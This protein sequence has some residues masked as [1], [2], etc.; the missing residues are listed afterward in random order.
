MCMYF[1]DRLLTQAWEML[2]LFLLRK[3]KYLVTA[4]SSQ[5]LSEEVISRKRA[6][7]FKGLHPFD[8]EDAGW[9]QLNWK[10]AWIFLFR[11]S[12]NKRCLPKTLAVP[13]HYGKCIN[14]PAAL[15]ILK[16][17]Q[18][19]RHQEGLS[20]L[21]LLCW[22]STPSVLQWPFW[23]VAFAAHLARYKLFQI[24]C[25]PSISPRNSFYYRG[26]KP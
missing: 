11:L 17:S 25:K 12:N 9:P 19:D 21:E 8:G 16:G 2:L 6:M 13:A 7:L 15:I 20:S 10:S 1:R 14:I 24:I 22:E 3:S 26:D 23:R 18:T 4:W 5:L